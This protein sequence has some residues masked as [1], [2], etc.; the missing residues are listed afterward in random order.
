M[1]LPHEIE[2]LIGEYSGKYFRVRNGELELS[3]VHQLLNMINPNVM[4]F[5]M[6]SGL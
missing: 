1:N 4:R 3:S 2:E 6:L 5:K